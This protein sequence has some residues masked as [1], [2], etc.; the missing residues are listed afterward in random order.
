MIRLPEEWYMHFMRLF[1]IVSIILLILV[2]IKEGFP[3]P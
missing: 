1:V 2:L 3:T